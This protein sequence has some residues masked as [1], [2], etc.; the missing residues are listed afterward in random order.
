[1]KRSTDI[2]RFRVKV[3]DAEPIDGASPV[4]PAEPIEIVTAEETASTK[5]MMNS[6][7]DIAADL[8]PAIGLAAG[9]RAPSFSIKNAGQC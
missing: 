5:D 7:A 8:E 2:A 6:L 4:S 3:R 1:M 9:N